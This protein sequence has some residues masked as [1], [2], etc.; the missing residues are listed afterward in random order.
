MRFDELFD[1]DGSTSELVVT[2]LALLE[3]TRLRMTRLYQSGNYEQLHVTLV[4]TDMT[5]PGAAVRDD[6]R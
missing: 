5:E 2:F 4:L 1:D 3:M 6:W